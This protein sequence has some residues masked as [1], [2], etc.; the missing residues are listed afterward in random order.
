MVKPKVL[1]DRILVRSELL[2]DKKFLLS[3]FNKD[4][5]V[6]GSAKY[7]Q[8]NTVIRI[9]YLLFNNGIPIKKKY[10]AV[11]TESKRLPSLLSNF[12]DE[13]SFLKTL[14]LT[15]EE[16]RTL[17]RSYTSLYPYLFHSIFVA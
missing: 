3:L 4:V 12:D 17:L 10:V 8:M 2:R 6:L 9:I 5:N 7:F 16:K 11:L 15:T 1:H 13:S 14:K